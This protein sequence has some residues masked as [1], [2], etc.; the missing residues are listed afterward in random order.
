MQPLVS[1]IIPAYNR[2]TTIE[3]AIDSV[4]RQTYKNLEVLVVDDCSTDATQEKVRKYKEQGVHLLIQR[5]HGGAAKA[6]NTGISEARGEYIA[7]QD[8]DDEWHPDKLEKQ[9]NEM[10][11]EGY[12]VSYCPYRLFHDQTET[13]VPSIYQDQD[14]CSVNIVSSLKKGNLIGTPT[15][16]LSKKVISQIG[17][18]DE[19]MCALQDYE[20]AIRLAKKYRIGYIGIPLV[21]AYR[22]DTCISNN[23]AFLQKAQLDMIKKHSDFIDMECM[24]NNL[25]ENSELFENGNIRW[26]ILEES[27]NIVEECQTNVRKEEVYKIA[28][29]YI[30]RRYSNMKESLIHRYDSFKERLKSE[31]FVIYGAGHFGRQ[32]LDDLEKAGVR[33]AYFLVTDLST[34]KSIKGIPILSFQNWNQR[35]MPVL[36]AVSWEKQNDITD[37]LSR[38]NLFDFCIYPFC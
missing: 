29:N 36:V 28:I 12:L 19:S 8:S 1:V 7:F 16:V 10:L 22:M 17:A 18:F 31:A 24:L 37:I 26:D 30:W 35:K 25:F 32:A 34:K 11:Q 9:I 23:K 38:H 3:R 33:P 21:N 5:E 20:Y 14:L 2:E 4:L 27:L 13:I 6:R 15:L